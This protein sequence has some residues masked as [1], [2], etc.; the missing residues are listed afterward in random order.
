MPL[1][2]DPTKDKREGV[3]KTFRIINI[4]LAIL[5]PLSVLLITL[6][7]GHQNGFSSFF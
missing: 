7:W 1:I 2:V 4:I 6:L 5:L 3:G